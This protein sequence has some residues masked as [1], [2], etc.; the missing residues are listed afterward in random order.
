M[1]HVLE[2]G[3]KD[4][5]PK[6]LAALGLG[7]HVALIGRV[8]GSGGAMEVGALSEHM[9]S[10]TSLDVGSR[11]DFQQMNACIAKHKLKPVI[12]RPS[13]SRKRP[14]RRVSRERQSLR[15]GCDSPLTSL[16]VVADSR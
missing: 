2:I 12:D 15:E 1:A 11:E 7:G 5:L 10:M 4:T 9:G 6:A 8:T 13:A 3:G 16:L 14:R